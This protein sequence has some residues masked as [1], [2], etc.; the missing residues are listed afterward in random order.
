MPGLGWADMASTYLE[1]RRQVFF[2]EGVV[3]DLDLGERSE[4]VW[5]EHD[6]NV[7]VLEFSHRVIDAPHQHREQRLRG[8]VQLALRMLHLQQTSTISATKS[9][10]I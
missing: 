9:R 1:V 4:V 3:V 7:D 5:H 6:G 8:A 10:S 2:V